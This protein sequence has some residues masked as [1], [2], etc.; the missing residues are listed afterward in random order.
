MPTLWGAQGGHNAAPPVFRAGPRG[1]GVANTDKVEVHSVFLM[2][3]T[4]AAAYVSYMDTGVYS[5]LGFYSEF[6][7]PDA[8]SG[9]AAQ[10]AYI[11]PLLNWYCAACTNNNTRESA[12]AIDLVT[13]SLPLQNLLLECW[14]PCFKNLMKVALGTA[15]PPVTTSVA[16]A[17]GANQLKNAIR[18]T[19]AAAV[20]YQQDASKKTFTEQYRSSIAQVMY[21]LCNVAN[22]DHLPEVHRL[23]AQSPKGQAYAILG[24]FAV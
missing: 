22:D 16:F 24:S 12:I 11:A 2:D 10:E 17:A 14:A 5:L 20:T 3:P 8:T 18:D 23:F 6:I 19:R 21:N 7:K 4:N 15:G 1:A 13:S 9:V